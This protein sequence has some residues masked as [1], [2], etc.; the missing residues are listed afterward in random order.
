MPM[1]LCKNLAIYS[2]GFASIYTNIELLKGI[3]RK[4]EFFQGWGR[5][6]GKLGT[7]PPLL[8]LKKDVGKLTLFKTHSCLALCKE[9][10]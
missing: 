9:I 10:K 7:Q 1:I 8:S 5:K 2:S 3:Y 4:A 6:L